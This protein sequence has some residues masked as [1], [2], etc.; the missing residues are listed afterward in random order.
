M[1]AFAIS[2]SEQH[3]SA[4]KKA[5]RGTGQASHVAGAHSAAHTLRSCGDGSWRG[6]SL[7][8]NCKRQ[9]AHSAP[10]LCPFEGASAWGIHAVTCAGCVACAYSCH[11]LC[12]TAAPFFYR[13]PHAGSVADSC[14]WNGACVTRGIQHLALL[15]AR[16]TGANSGVA[17]HLT[18]MEFFP[19]VAALHGRWASGELLRCMPAS[20]RE[21]VLGLSQPRWQ[22]QMTGCAQRMH[23]RPV[24]LNSSVASCQSCSLCGMRLARDS[25]SSCGPPACSYSQ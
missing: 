8:G 14:T 5:L 17:R 25:A 3:P 13:C 11:W 1:G 4:T 18:A 22:S 16:S 20:A 12:L 21:H 6:R 23:H 10:S 2:L 19:T 15:G 7:F 9:C 24:R